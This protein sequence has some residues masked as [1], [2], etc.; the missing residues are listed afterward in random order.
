MIL[1]NFYL[2][3]AAGINIGLIATIWSIFPFFAAI[4]EYI[5]FKTALDK[6]QIVG[7]L[8][9]FSCAVFLGLSKAYIT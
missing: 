8:L 5:V 4:T 3:N 1:T 2:S 9:I 6:K 7:M